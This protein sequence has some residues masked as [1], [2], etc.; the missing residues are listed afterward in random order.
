MPGVFNESRYSKSIVIKEGDVYYIGGIDPLYYK[1]YPDNIIHIWSQYDRL[2]LLAK[3][4]YG[5]H[6]LWWIIAEFNNI[7]YFFQE[8][9]VGTKIYLPSYT[10]VVTEIL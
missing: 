7:M 6:K 9:E 5:D 2:D 1:D 3:R 10:R 4:Y 8:I